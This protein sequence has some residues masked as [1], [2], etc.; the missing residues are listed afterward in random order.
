MVELPPFPVDDGTLDMLCAAM[1]P[2]G[3]GDETAERSCMGD[4]LVLMSQLG[5]SD[6]EAVEENHGT[7]RMMRDPCYG[8]FDVI[9]ALID[10]VRRLRSGFSY[11]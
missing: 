2:R 5:G 1:D 4:F 6:T 9:K 11:G 3:A 8:E 7:I 10:E